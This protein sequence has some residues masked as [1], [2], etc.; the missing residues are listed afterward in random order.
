[1]SQVVITLQN[2]GC[3]NFKELR[4]AFGDLNNCQLK[5]PFCFTLKQRP[6]YKEISTLTNQ[7]L[8]SVKIIRFTGGEPLLCQEQVDAILQE[9]FKIQHHVDG[10][11]DL[12]VIQTNAIA[13]KKLNFDVFRKIT[14]P[15]L[16]EVSFKG[17]N[18]KE[19]QY[20]TFK[21]CV[22]E[23]AAEKIMSGQVEGYRII[24][25]KFSMQ[26]NIGIL[27]RLGIFHSS[28]KEPSFKFIF[29]D[30]HKLMFN[31]DSW[32]DRISDI[33]EEQNNLWG[34]IFEGK[35][36]LEKLKTPADGSPVMGK[37]YKEIIELL[38][39]SGLL[40]EE[41]SKLPNQFQQ[42]YFYKRGNEIY[43]KAARAIS[44]KIN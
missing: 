20:L 35:F 41:K 24:S 7:N 21:D 3:E 14:I 42:K 12:I 6:L 15:I 11:L 33:L 13:V 4:V 1:M 39:L 10:N 8:D 28:V 18:I 9:L 5:C 34:D 32:D 38:K 17:T 25:E 43:W 40:V 31:P 23:K 26:P 16:F 2:C 30:T 29:P 37:R 44:S 27:A 19:Y 36:V 22:T